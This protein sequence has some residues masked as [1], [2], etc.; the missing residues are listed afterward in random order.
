MLASSPVD[1]ATGLH[2]WAVALYG[3]PPSAATTSGSRSAALLAGVGP[4]AGSPRWE[5]LALS[6]KE[7]QVCP[8]WVRWPDVL[9]NV[10]RN[11]EWIGFLTYL[12][13]AV[14]LSEHCARRNVGS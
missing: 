10:V 5:T 7:T 1:G 14:S 11:Q 8:R 12:I 2:K 9:P 13:V 4:V 3:R 6:H